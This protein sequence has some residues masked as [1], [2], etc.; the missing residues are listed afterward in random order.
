MNA[1]GE[2]WGSQY[3]GT[4]CGWDCGLP[5]NQSRWMQ[6]FDDGVSFKS[7]VAWWLP[8]LFFL[9]EEVERLITMDIPEDEVKQADYLQNISIPATLIHKHFGDQIKNALSSGK[10]AKDAVLKAICSGFKEATEPTICLSE[11]IETNECL[12]NNGGCWQ[13][14]VA[15]IT[16][17]RD[18]FRG[19]VCECPIVEGVKFVGNGYTHCEASGPLRC[20]S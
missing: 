12:E 18:T 5:R 11:D 9:I 10:L 13:D 2:L 3:G 20:E 4:I 1:I 17:C 6:S 8:S 19:R 15:N 14:R 16:A 7:M